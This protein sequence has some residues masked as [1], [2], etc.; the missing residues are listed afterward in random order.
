M[1]EVHVP[2]RDGAGSGS[3]TAKVHEDKLI[4]GVSKKQVGWLHRR[5]KERKMSG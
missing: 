3:S 2:V 5:G 4:T 1:M